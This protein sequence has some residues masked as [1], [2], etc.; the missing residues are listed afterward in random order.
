MKAI[1]TKMRIWIKGKGNQYGNED[2][3]VCMVIKA[4]NK[5]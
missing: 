5:K 3:D 4:I 1:N 2:M